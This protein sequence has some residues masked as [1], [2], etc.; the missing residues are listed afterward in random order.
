MPFKPMGCG[1]AYVIGGW[2]TQPNSSASNLKFLARKWTNSPLRSHQLASAATDDGKFKAEI[3]PI[4]I[5]TRKGEIIIDTDEP[6][7]SDTSL[8]ALAKLRPAP[9]SRMAM[10]PPGTRLA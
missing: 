10:S 7:R 2:V 6:I 5:K 1:A 9:L 8:E 4:T 3:V